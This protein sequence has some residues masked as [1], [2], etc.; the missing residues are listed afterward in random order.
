MI[1]SSIPFLYY[2][3]PVVLIIYF[4]TPRIMKNVVLF[5]SS[6]FF[7]SW[8]EP[9]YVILMFVTVLVNYV[10]GILIGTAKNKTISK[11]FLILSIAFSLSL[12][13]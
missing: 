2:F 6:L 10:L 9:K 3:L 7:Y 8:G 4:A 11:A 5:F 12:L 13:A 1:F